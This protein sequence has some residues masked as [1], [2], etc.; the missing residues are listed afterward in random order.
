MI[1]VVVHLFPGCVVLLCEYKSEKLT[2]PIEIYII[3]VHIT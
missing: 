3:D 2:W 1:I